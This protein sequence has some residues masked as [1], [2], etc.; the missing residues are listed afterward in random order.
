MEWFLRAAEAGNTVA[1][2]NLAF[3]Y[4]N[5]RGIDVDKREAA[6]WARQ[7]AERGHAPGQVMLAECYLSGQ[8]VERNDERAKLWLQ[9]AARQGNRRAKMLLETLGVEIENVTGTDS[10]SPPSATEQSL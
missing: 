1:M 10:G 3:C 2:T 8:G 5:G 6:E 4:L 9:A 7:A